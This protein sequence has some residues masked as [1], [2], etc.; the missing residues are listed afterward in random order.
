M[1]DSAN[2]QETPLSTHWDQLFSSIP[3]G[4][5]NRLYCIAFTPR[6]GSTWLGDLLTKSGIVGIPQEWFNPDLAKTRAQQSGST[7]LQGY[8]SY[9]KRVMRTKE[10]FG[11]EM[12][13]PQ[14]DIVLQSEGA[15]Q[16]EDIQSW[17]FLRR[18]DFVAQAVSLY[19]AEMTGRFHSIQ[20]IKPTAPVEYNAQRISKNV[21]R[22]MAHEFAYSLFFQ[23]RKIA[24]VELWHEELIALPPADVLK[25]FTEVLESSAEDIARVN[26]ET[27]ASVHEK[28][29]DEDSGKLIHQFKTDYPGI[30]QYWERNRGAR[31]IKSFRREHPEL[32]LINDGGST[33]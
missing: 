13:W 7:N 12:T 30:I 22:I 11:L 8:Y 5:A 17:F 25:L 1:P 4:T 3:R 20:D 6:S 18:K 24:P 29:G 15:I 2:Y 21:Q 28:I 14:L 33:G 23:R 32:E 27:L 10:V 16:F 31:S 26:I 19:K 9:L